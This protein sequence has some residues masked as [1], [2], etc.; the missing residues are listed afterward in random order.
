LR[1]AIPMVAEVSGYD[2]Q[3]GYPISVGGYTEGGLITAR[4]WDGSLESTR[5]N[6]A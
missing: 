1:A 4:L 6:F 5:D 2:S 3:D